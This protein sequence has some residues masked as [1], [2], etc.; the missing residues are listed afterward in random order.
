MYS[1][2]LERGK[3][4]KH[5]AAAAANG[6]QLVTWAGTTY[7]GR[8]DE[9]LQKHVK[10]EFAVRLRAEKRA[11]GSGFETIKWKQRLYQD[12]N[13]EIARAN[14]RMLMERTLPPRVA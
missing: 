2:D 4:A 10:P 11:G 13:I 12:M 5:A 6:M 9:F 14:Y 7:G 1:S 8:G 3:R